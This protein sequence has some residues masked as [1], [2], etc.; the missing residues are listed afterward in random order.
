[1]NEFCRECNINFYAER[2]NATTLFITI[3]LTFRIFKR[4][5]DWSCDI[6]WSTVIFFKIIVCPTEANND[7]YYLY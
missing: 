4:E 3:L 7:K 1:M 6:A 2:E 5:E